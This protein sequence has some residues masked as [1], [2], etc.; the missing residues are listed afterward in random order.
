[1]TDFRC[2]LD[3]EARGEGL[4]GTA[5]RADRF[6]LVEFPTPWPAKAVEV[7]DDDL[8]AGLV[9][10]VDAVK[11]KL[12]LVRRHGQR[13]GDVRRWAV[14]DVGAQRVVWG[15]WEQQPDLEGLI[16][17]IGAPSD[18]CARRSRSSHCA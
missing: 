5:S 15:S 3:S 13:T 1:M 14:T 12:L 8:R 16:E 4:A 6:V 18:G 17:A 10:A 7:F 2:S 9:A 11:A